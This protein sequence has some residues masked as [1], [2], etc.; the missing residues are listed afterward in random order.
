MHYRHTG[1]AN[2]DMFAVTRTA[3]IILMMIALTTICGCGRGAKLR[4]GGTATYSAEGVSFQLPPGWVKGDNLHYQLGYADDRIGTVMVTPLAGG[5]LDGY[6]DTAAKQSGNVA[7]R[8]RLEVDGHKAVELI[9][10]SD[11]KVVELFMQRGE[12]VVYL[13][14]SVPPDAFDSQL[15]AFRAAGQS[16]RFDR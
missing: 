1:Q 3:W 7:A 6:V 10:D 11:N 13:S 5:T 2:C 8:R 16:V 4:G 15:P 14:F 9:L 12:E